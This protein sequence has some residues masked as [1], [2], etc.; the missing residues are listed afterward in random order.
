MYK[1]S[2]QNSRLMKFFHSL[3]MTK[4]LQNTCAEPLCHVL[5]VNYVVNT[6]RLNKICMDLQGIDR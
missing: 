2:V 6:S 1:V 3:K 4:K 5:Y